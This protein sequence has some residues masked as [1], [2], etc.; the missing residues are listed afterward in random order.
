MVESMFKYSFQSKLYIWQRSKNTGNNKVDEAKAVYQ[1]Q[2]GSRLN[3]NKLRDL[4]WSLDVL[5]L[6]KNR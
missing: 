3:S 6:K 2:N 4:A 5:D 1:A